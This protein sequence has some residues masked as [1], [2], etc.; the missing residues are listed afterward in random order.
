MKVKHYLYFFVWITIFIVYLFI[1]NCEISS[2]GIYNSLII[3]SN[4]I[5]FFS[6]RI[7]KKHSTIIWVRIM[8][9]ITI[10]WGL[11][12][13]MYL[14]LDK[15]SRSQSSYFDYFIY[16]SI[17]IGVLLFFISFSDGL[18]KKEPNALIKMLNILGSR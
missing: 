18:D 17:F 10:L 14:I 16:P 4:I 9:V 1:E 11:F 12:C 6:S 7:S 13:L 2:L 15:C 3:I 5:F 8:S